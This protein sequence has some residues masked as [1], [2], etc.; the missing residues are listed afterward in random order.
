MMSSCTSV[1]H[2]TR[3][4]SMM[5][6]EEKEMQG[7]IST[8]TA[9]NDVHVAFA[10]F[11][12]V[13]VFGGLNRLNRGDFGTPKRKRYFHKSYEGGVGY[14]TVNENSLYF[15]A[16]GGMGYGRGQ[17]REIAHDIGTFSSVIE[18]IIPTG[19]DARMLGSYRKFFLNSGIGYIDEHVDF[20]F[21]A[22][23]T[24]GNFIRLNTVLIDR[25]TGE[26]YLHPNFHPTGQETEFLYAEPAITI[27]AGYEPVKLF[28][29]GGM[30]WPI[31]HSPDLPSIFFF[32][33]GVAVDMKP[34]MFKKDAE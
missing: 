25:K 16:S 34:G 10:P 12:N 21:H 15:E 32:S 4:H 26:E 11:K 8:G 14:W 28:V 9:G 23:L 6:S 30:L 3:V 27:R 33:A 31:N 1:Y 2:P 19:N 7:S 20:L 18:P 22:R 29:Q 17:T 24:Y 5:L 13:G